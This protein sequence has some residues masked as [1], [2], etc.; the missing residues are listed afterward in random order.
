MDSNM[1]VNLC[2]DDLFNTAMHTVLGLERMAR[3][4]REWEGEE[5]DAEKIEEMVAELRRA[6]GEVWDER[7]T[8]PPKRGRRSV[9]TGNA[10]RIATFNNKVTSLRSHVAKGWEQRGQVWLKRKF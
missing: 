7:T 1:S 6:V 10:E 8:T 2:D 5:V 9:S 3:D 4:L